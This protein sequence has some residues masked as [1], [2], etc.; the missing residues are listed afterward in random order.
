MLA[1]LGQLAFVWWQQ[2]QDP[3]RGPMYVAAS[4]QYICASFITMAAMVSAMLAARSSSSV[5]STPEVFRAIPWLARLADPASRGLGLPAAGHK[6]GRG[7][8]EG[9]VR[10]RNGRACGC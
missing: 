10:P 9:K 8:H 4:C 5:P 6:A 1:L 2:T 3:M 7:E